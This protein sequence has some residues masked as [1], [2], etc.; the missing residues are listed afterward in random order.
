MSG[1]GGVAANPILIGAA[2]VLV[3]IVAV[4]LAYNAN[5]GLPFVPSYK[6]ELEARSAANLVRGNEVRVGGARVGTVAEISADRRRDG[7]AY[8]VLSLK[9][10]ESIAPLP[11][12]STFVIRTRSVLGQKY[13]EVTPGAADRGWEDGARV[14][15]RQMTPEPVEF[16]EVTNMFDE[17][18]REGVRG[19]LEGGG[20][21]LAGRGASLNAAIGALRPL[22][23]DVQPVLRTLADEDTD[24]AGFARGL[25]QAAAEVAPV[26]EQQARLFIELDRT[27]S[28]INEVRDAYQETIAE[29]PATLDA[30]IRAFPAQRP[31]LANA[32]RLFAEL[33][34]GVQA[35]RSAAPDLAGALQTGQPT[36]RR[37]VAFNRRLEPLFGALRAFAEDPR[38][39][40][41][42]ARTTELARELSPTLKFLAPAQTQCNYLSLL[43]RNVASLLSEG[44][45]NGTWQRFII[46][47]TPQGPDNE[48]GPSSRPANGP[49]R[50]N[51]FHVNPYPNTA[52]PGQPRECEAGNEQYIP[53]RR[54]LSNTPR[55]DSARTEGDP[56]PARLVRG[57]R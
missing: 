54:V 2:T 30:A 45:E 3:T 35:L 23:A 31:F 15:V 7:D 56:R 39:G 46:V 49:G 17:R 34:P 52:A 22:L 20:T 1:R 21:A 9:L 24:L 8:A 13:V 37:A 44:D 6:L 28:A 14:P 50:D 4:F 42:I 47:A 10:E 29:G 40:R 27:F 32:E 43:L 16:D 26:A 12:D 18:T 51:H 36:L 41:G 38:T 55:L 48:G 53:G 33:R 11:V 57:A 5:A 19:Q 25:G